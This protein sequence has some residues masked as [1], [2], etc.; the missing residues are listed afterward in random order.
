MDQLFVYILLIHYLGDFVLQTDWQAKN[1]SS[2]NFAL[3]RHVL[4]YSLTWFA[5]SY[6]YFG[7][8]G[9]AGMFWLIT[10][11]CHFATDY[12]TSRA[13]KK[14][15]EKEDHHTGFMIIGFNQVLHLL[16]LWFTFKIMF[17]YT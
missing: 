16:Q 1:K 6:I 8:I 7:N 12:I 14:Q 9:I 3:N 11:I 15:F 4:T 13:V 5:A 10:Y 2:S 17:P